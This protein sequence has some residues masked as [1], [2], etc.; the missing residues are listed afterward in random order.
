MKKILV[1]GMAILL[2]LVMTG[3]SFAALKN[4]QMKL[5]VGDEVY[6]CGCGESCPCLTMS[7]SPGKCTCGKDLVK[8]EV[9]KVEKGKATVMVNGKEQVFPTKGKYACACGPK[10]NCDT[11]SQSPGKCG[12]GSEMKPVE[13][14]KPK[15]EKEKAP[16]TQ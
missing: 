8:G 7:K 12:C 4:G 9:T 15:A 2:C 3:I 10:C 16:A 5:K 14:A 11:I 13:A 1:I 6:V